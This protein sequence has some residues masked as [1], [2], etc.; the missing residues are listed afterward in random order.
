MQQ[1]T[2]YNITNISVQ[3]LIIK[4]CMSSTTA[5]FDGLRHLIA[6]KISESETGAKD[7][8]SEDKKWLGKRTEQGLLCTD[9]KCLENHQ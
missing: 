9:C 3:P 1:E 2:L 5:D 4:P 6:L 7:K 8:N